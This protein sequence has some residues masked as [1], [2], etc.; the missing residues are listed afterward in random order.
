M[1]ICVSL[2][3]IFPRH[4][5]SGQP[6]LSMTPVLSRQLTATSPY[7]FLSLKGRGNI[8]RVGATFLDWDIADPFTAIGRWELQ[9]APVLGH[10]AARD[11]NIFRG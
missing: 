1:T 7:I 9:L 3:W 5:E 6:R 8:V 2:I 4:I 10:G 11:L